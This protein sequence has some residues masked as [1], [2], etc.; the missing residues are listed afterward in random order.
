MRLVL[1]I[2]LALGCASPATAEEAACAGESLVGEIERDKPDVW[3]KAVAEFEAAPNS[4]GLL[5]KV[6]KEGVAPSWLFGTIHL[7]DRRVV[8]LRE[9]V[10]EA[11][12]AASVVVL[13]SVDVLAP[14][15]DSE[16]PQQ[17]LS[18]AR[19]PEGKTFDADF[20][21]AEKDALGKLTAA[22]GIPYFAARRLKPW[23]LAVSLSIPPCAHIA[24]MRGEPVLD[25]R[26][27]KE[28]VAAGKKVVGLET[29]A[30]QLEAMRSVDGAIGPEALLELVQLGPEGIAGWYATMVDLYLQE[31]PTLALALIRAM[32]ELSVMSASTDDMQDPLVR[33]RNRRM[34]GR[35]LPMLERGGAFAAVGALHLSGEDGL[36]ALL[37]RDGY[38]VTRV[39]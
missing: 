38:A 5:W 8:T 35:L 11:F 16:I 3:A 13:E 15:P 33:S 37:R 1:A 31:R 24:A 20:S 32:P 36:V 34:H 29:G 17:L 28:A 7:P 30:E 26:L 27:H 23:F 2:L 25:A 19:L 12:A 21:K 14:D 39:E 6:A 22:Q 4:S 18:M 9:P 10:A